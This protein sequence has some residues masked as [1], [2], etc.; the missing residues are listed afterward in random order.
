MGK[1]AMV[2]RRVRASPLK[3]AITHQFSLQVGAVTAGYAH[4]KI[5]EVKLLRKTKLQ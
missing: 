2:G 3:R 4:V 5:K 1:N